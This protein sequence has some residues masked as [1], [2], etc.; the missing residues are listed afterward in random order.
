[1]AEPLQWVE[2]VDKIHFKGL[3]RE[4]H[5]ITPFCSQYL[6]LGGTRPFGKKT[7]YQSDCAWFNPG[8]NCIEEHLFIIHSIVK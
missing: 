5:T 3:E 2:L 1:M 6:V 8:K 4:G 7:N